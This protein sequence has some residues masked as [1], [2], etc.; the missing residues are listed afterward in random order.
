MSSLKPRDGG[1]VR[2]KWAVVRR[3]NLRVK[4]VMATSA[5]VK[6]EVYIIKKM[7]VNMY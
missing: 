2:R 5:E 4:V 7:K 1:E 6:V 3:G